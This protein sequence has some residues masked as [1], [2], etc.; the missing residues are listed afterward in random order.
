MIRRPRSPVLVGAL[1]LCAA[2]AVGELYVIYERGSA[3]RDGEAKLLQR[4]SELM[5]MATIMP[6]PTR[7]VAVAIEE[8][9]ARA[10]ATL[11]TMQA[12]LQGRGPAAE[13]W[14]T[15][16]IPTARTD[17]YFDLASYVERLR[18]RARQNEVAIRPEAARFGFAAHANEGPELERIG[19][20]FR[21]RLLAQ[22]LMEALLDARPRAILAVKR[23]PAFTPLERE[24][25]EATLAEAEAAAVIAAGGDL[26]DTNSPQLELPEGPDY[27]AIDPRASARRAGFVDT[28]AFKFVFTGQTAALRTFLNR[29]ALFELPILVREVEV[30]LASPDE[31]ADFA[32]EEPSEPE[33]AAAAP[34]GSPSSVV[35]SI[36]PVPAGNAVRPAT[37]TPVA[38]RTPVRRTIDIPIVAKSVSKFTVIVEFVE[39]VAPPRPPEEPAAL[40]QS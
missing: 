1:T 34:E 14:R 25:R 11:A 22:Y 9:L 6:P 20:V 8:D 28:I 21:Q 39:W 5:A 10:H 40:P 35:L 17:A 12:E 13:R 31:T 26:L 16:R 32:V 15:A 30:E 23:E 29:L 19:A 36:D 3:S 37:L 4:Q 33:V 24:A 7:D 18:E 38:G 27:F 2:L